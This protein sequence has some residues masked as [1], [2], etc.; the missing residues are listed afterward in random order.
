MIEITNVEEYSKFL[1]EYKGKTNY[2]F[3]GVK[4]TDYK[5]EP[6]ILRITDSIEI[7]DKINQFFEIVEK[8]IEKEKTDDI[9]AMVLCQHQN[10][11]SPLL[12]FSFCPIVA[13]FFAVSNDNINQEYNENDSV[14][15]ILDLKKY[16]EFLHKNNQEK[17][18]INL[19][20]SYYDEGYLDK[21]IKIN[22]YPI[23]FYTY[24]NNIRFINQKSCFLLWGHDERNLEEI[25]GDEFDSIFTKVIIKGQIKAEILNYID[26][27]FNVNEQF[28]F[29]TEQ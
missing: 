1:E 28:M 19:L 15:F 25:L 18:Y 23:L 22:K 4:S 24:S 21:T 7:S 9:E 2:I 16:K 6:N 8:Q 14:I 3:R 5:L 10:H 26:S 29:P 11:Y 17:I 13:T 27:K 12:D 20:K